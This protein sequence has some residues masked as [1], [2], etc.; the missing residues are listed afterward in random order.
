MGCPMCSNQIVVSSNCLATLNPELAKQWHP[1]KNRNFT[2]YDIVPGSGKKV[3]WLGTCGHEWE[4][5]VRNRTAGKDCY[6]CR[7]I[8][9][10]R[11]MLDEAKSFADDGV[12]SETDRG[13]L[14]SAVAQA[15]AGKVNSPIQT[16]LSL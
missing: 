9:R 4:T 8:K 5:S 16:T 7:H 1:T 13:D 6:R 10:K 15:P 2:A 3:W 11:T 12:N 14:V